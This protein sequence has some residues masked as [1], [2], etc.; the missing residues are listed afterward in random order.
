MP[1]SPYLMPHLSKNA[2]IYKYVKE[3]II[4]ST[5]F[6]NIKPYIMIGYLAKFESTSTAV[7]SYKGTI[8]D[9]F[10]NKYYLD[11]M[12]KAGLSNFL[13]PNP[14]YGYTREAVM[15]QNNQNLV[16]ADN[17]AE[18]AGKQGS[19][20]NNYLENNMTDAQNA[21]VTSTVING[22]TYIGPYT[23]KRNDSKVEKI[24]V[25][26]KEASGIVITSKS[27]NIQNKKV[28]AV[29]KTPNNKKFY[30]VVDSKLDKITSIKLTGNKEVKALKAR[31]VVLGCGV[32]QNWIVYKAEETKDKPIIELECPEKNPGILE[33]S[34][35]DSV[36]GKSTITTETGDELSLEGI[37][38]KI[39]NGKYGWV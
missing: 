28:K 16:D 8:Q 36:T 12:H 11:R 33:I 15:L 20:K 19:F 3:D 30:I 29:S 24:T 31:L 35:K 7:H 4:M 37:G 14:S 34:K 39:Y 26:G 10:N 6:Y 2:T 13:V 32:A 27:T 1:H 9:I 23:I 17:Y 21:K 18:Q 22:K 5:D 38:F 25:N